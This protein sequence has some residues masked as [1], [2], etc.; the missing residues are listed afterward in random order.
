LALQAN[1]IHDAGQD[2]LCNQHLTDTHNG[3][4][5]LDRIA[6]ND[7]NVPEFPARAGF[8]AIDV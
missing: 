4:V 8:L 6:A 5:A 1:A 3:P 2:C 7:R